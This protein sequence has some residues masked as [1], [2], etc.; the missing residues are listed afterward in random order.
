MN[1]RRTAV[2]A[3]VAAVMVAMTL[4][5]CSETDRKEARTEGR[6]ATTQASA[7]VDDA[8][9]TTKVKAALLAD[10]QVKG[11]QINVDTNGGNVR[12]TGTVDS[13]AQIRRAMEVAKGITGV[14]K[15]DNNLVASASA[16]PGAVPGTQPPGTA[17]SATPLPN[18]ATPASK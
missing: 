9:I 7:A 15:V 17:P 12:L 5:A 11:T 1:Q 4:G 3:A 10:D 6:Q 14:Q 8:A 18:S 16:A 13:Q 2:G